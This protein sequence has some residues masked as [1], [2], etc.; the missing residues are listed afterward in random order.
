MTA[1]R[2]MASFAAIIVAGLLGCSNPSDTAP[3]TSAPN[4]EVPTT[5]LPSTTTVPASTSTST[6]PED[7]VFVPPGTDLAELVEQSEP[8]AVFVLQA[9]VHQSHDPDAHVIPKAGQTFLGE[10]GAILDG[11]GVV[12][13]A[14]LDSAGTAPDVT[15]RGLI[16]Q[17]YANP[18]ERGA[19]DTISPG[20]KLE[21]NEIRDNAGAGVNLRG[22]GAVL[23]RNF[24][25]HNDQIGVL[26]Q[27][28]SG[29]RVT[30]NEIAHNNPDDSYDPSWEAGG[31]KFLR[32]TDLYVADNHVHDNHGPGL[33]TD[34][35]NVGTVYEGNRVIDNTGPGIFHEISG[36]AVIRDNVVTGNA[37]DFYMGGILVANSDHVTV[38]GNIVSGNNGG[39]VGLQEHRD[40]PLLVN[41][42]VALNVISHKVGVT[43]VVIQSGPDVTRSGSLV[44]RE[45]TYEVAGS[46]PFQWGSRRLTREQWAALG[47]DV[48]A[49]SP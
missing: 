13:F 19:V 6:W 14:F 30:G 42:E 26:I 47:L 29:A 24:I 33:W 11:A 5:S 38:T 44:F 23:D 1:R 15:I 8:G 21:A 17:N 28:S 35:R 40:G 16:I 43:G 32:T 20:W 31:T 7:A 10:P 46:R 25:H 39:V 27:D 37:H 49:G 4:A 22:D 36:S 18:P 48:P 9:G 45:N 41:L 12:P 34:H 2:R 3:T